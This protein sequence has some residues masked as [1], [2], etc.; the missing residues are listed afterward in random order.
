MLPQKEE[1]MIIESSW[2]R[3]FEIGF[4]PADPLQGNILN[5]RQLKEIMEENQ[6]LIDCAIPSLQKL[7]PVLKKTGHMVFLVDRNG[8]IIYTSGDSSFE[9]LARN[10]QLQVGANWHEGKRGTNAMGL[11]LVEKRPVR[12]HGDQHFNMMARF[13]TC[14]ASPIFSPSGELAGAINISGKKEQYEPTIFLLTQIIADDIQNKLLLKQQKLDYLLMNNELEYTTNKYIS[15]PLLSLNEDNQIIRAN[16]KAKYLLG[17]D[18]IGKKLKKDQQFF[19]EKIPSPDNKMDRYIAVQKQEVHKGLFNF[20]DIIGSCPLLKKAKHIATRAAATD[21]PVLIY[22]ETGTGKEMFAQSIHSASN[23]SHSPF[24]A[25]N[26]SALP[27][28]LI[29]SELFGYVSGA[30]TGAQRGGKMGLFEAAQ[31][32]TI[33]LDEIGDMSLRSQ[34]ALLRVLQEK[35]VTPV[36]SIESKKI[37]IRVIAATNKD[38]LDE[39]KAERFRADLY[40]RL[41]GIKITIPPLR[42]RS[43]IKELTTY[44]LKKECGPNSGFSETAFEMLLRYSWPG[45]VRELSSSLIQASFLADGMFI[46][47]EHLQLAEIERMKENDNT[48]ISLKENEQTVIEA[49][50]RAFNGNISKASQQLD[51]SR[52]TLYRKMKEYKI[53]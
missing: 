14:A 48:I 16:K 17:H 20:S 32:G 38:L 4:N 44:L 21:I 19:I 39:I 52:N 13:L 36:G 31:N 53:E 11:A 45:N 26:C 50:L 37:D 23:R 30:F 34:A 22:G 7:F 35:Q 49:A 8:T 40:Y 2:K 10:V 5:E 27:E 28:T 9:K 1:E 12:I 51:I 47:A 18:C 15:A 29:E 42:K 43:D 46:E 6:D 41:K 33:F 25:V 3:C 24:I